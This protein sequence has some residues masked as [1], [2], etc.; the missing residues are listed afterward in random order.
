MKYSLII[1]FFLIVKTT[2]AQEDTLRIIDILDKMDSAIT[3]HKTLEFKFYKEERCTDHNEYSISEVK[4][5]CDSTY[6]VYMK[7]NSPRD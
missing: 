4:V 5:I 7:S 3:H 1:L 6:C 2:I